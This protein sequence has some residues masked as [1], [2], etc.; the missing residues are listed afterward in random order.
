MQAVWLFEGRGRRERLAV[1]RERGPGV[2]GAGGAEVIGEGKRQAEPARPARR[3]SRWTRAATARAR[4]PRPGWRGS[5]CR[6]VGGAAGRRSRP[7]VP[8]A[9][10][11]SPPAGRPSALRRSARAVSRSVPGARPIPRSIRP[12]CSASSVP[13]CSATVSGGWLGSITPPEPTRIA[14]VAAASWPAR[15]A[16]AELAMPGRLWCSATQY[17]VKPRLSACRARST[18]RRSAS[19]VD[20][21]AGTGHR[22]STDSGTGRRAATTRRLPAPGRPRQHGPGGRSRAQ[23]SQPERTGATVRRHDL[24]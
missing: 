11:R 24:A 5:W 8:R 16:G 3:C 21:P 15:T 12:G 20:S 22:S 9:G 2:G 17:L 1:E 19:P 14:A 6:V 23:T 4:C 18:L 13:N 10:G 7:A